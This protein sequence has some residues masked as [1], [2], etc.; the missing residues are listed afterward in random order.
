MPADPANLIQQG[1]DT[2][3]ALVGPDD[4]DLLIYGGTFD[5]PHRAHL[6]LP[7]RV[8]EQLNADAV[9]YIP[10]GRSPHKLDHEQSPAHHR[11]A[12]LRRALAGQRWARLW[13]GEIEQDNDGPSYTVDT[14][15]RLHD[16][17]GDAVRLRL[18]IG[19]DQIDKFDTW[20]R[21][22]RVVELA[23]P[24]VMIR[25]PHDRAAIPDNWQSRLVEVPAMDISSTNIR[26]RIRNQQPI[27]QLIPEAVADYI[28]ATNLYQAIF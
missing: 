27:D 2:P 28:E 23:E 16:Q 18:L 7:R 13:L 21:H 22:E 24:V 15:E 11:V 17:L 19:A 4:R 5:P 6:E 10:A 12:M 20:V 3:V 1:P 9:V 26:E 14:L 8:C 25:P